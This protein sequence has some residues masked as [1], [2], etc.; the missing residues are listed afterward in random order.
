MTVGQAIVSVIGIAALF[1]AYLLAEASHVAVFEYSFLIAAGIWG[2]VLWGQVPD[3]LALL[4]M[5]C[6]IGAGIVIIKRSKS[7]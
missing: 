5:T 3:A 6:I 7:A 1:R 4:G 2:Y